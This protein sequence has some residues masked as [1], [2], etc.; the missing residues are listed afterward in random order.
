M[1]FERFLVDDEHQPPQNHMNCWNVRILHTVH[2]TGEHEFFPAEVYY[3]D[4]TAK[5]PRAYGGLSVS[6][7]K[8]DDIKFFAEEILAACRKPVLEAGDAFPA[9]YK[10]R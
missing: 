9:E 3:H 4:K 6:G 10:P 8:L 5:M 1:A 7:E 2:P